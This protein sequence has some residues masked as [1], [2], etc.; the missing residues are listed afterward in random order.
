[1]H[2]GPWPHDRADGLINL[3]DTDARMREW[4]RRLREESSKGEA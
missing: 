4:D 2:L 3:G 1:V